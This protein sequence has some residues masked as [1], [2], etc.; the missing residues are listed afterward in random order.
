MRMSFWGRGCEGE[1]PWVFSALSEEGQRELAGLL[2]PIEYDKDEVIFQEGEPAF[3]LYIICRGRVK[4]TKRS[5]KGKRQILKLVGPGEFLGEKTMF[6]QE[7]YTAFAKTLEPTK[8]YFVE[9][10]AFLDFLLRHPQV[11]INLIE[12]LAREL[13]SFQ[14]RLLEISYEGSTERLA[15]LLLKVGEVCG[16][17]EDRRFYLGVELSRAELAEMAGISTETA[18][19]TLS[20]LREGGLVELEGHKIYIRDREGLERLAQPS[21]ALTRENRL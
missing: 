17:K 10:G 15:R 21:S 9:R 5:S 8:L 19:R 13:K 18:I 7:V 6:D 4:L 1:G 12:K 2:R 20:R 3:G 14:S 16:V 11:A